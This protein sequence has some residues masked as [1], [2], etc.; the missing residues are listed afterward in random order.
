MSGIFGIVSTAG[1]A[2]GRDA[3]RPMRTTMSVWGKTG[4]EDT[5]LG[6]IALGYVADG[7]NPADNNQPLALPDAPEVTLVADVRL[8]DPEELRTELGPSARATESEAEL[9]LRAYLRWGEA[10][11]DRLYGAFAFAVADANRGVVLL[12]RD[13]I[14]QRPLHYWQGE[15]RLIF[16]TSAEAIVA[17]PLVPE[18]FDEL[19]LAARVTGHYGVLLER[20]VYAGV[21]K[22]PP[23][24][25]LVAQRGRTDQRRYWFPERTA[26]QDL[27][28]PVE[29]VHKLREALFRATR[30]AV[31][32]DGS[33]GAHVS[34]GLDSS[35]VAVLADR[36][37][38][39]HGRQLARVFSWSPPLE[40]P[41]RPEDERTRVEDVVRTIGAPVTYCD[42]DVRMLEADFDRELAM[43]P[44]DALL[45]EDEV[46]RQA[47][48][49][50]IEIILSGWGGDEVASFS[51]GG[52]SAEL[53]R[54]RQWRMLIREA[55]EPSRRTGTGRMRIAWRSA[56]T[57][58]HTGIGTMLPE[59]LAHTLR[60]QRRWSADQA[61]IRRG[62]HIHPE[63]PRLMREACVRSRPRPDM[64]ATRLIYL[65]SGHLTLR[66]E[67][68]AAAA[69]R[70]G[71]E[72]RYPL[73]DRGLI[74]L[75]LSFPAWLWRRDCESRWIFR[76]A[77]EPFVPSSVFQDPKEEPARLRSYLDL[78]LSRPSPPPDPT[79]PVPTVFAH[80]ARRRAQEAAREARRQ[81]P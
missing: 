80:T 52:R 60:L 76:A 8:D 73:L 57:I 41:V 75:C 37:L 39:A 54:T 55:A 46:L 70:V 25:V 71:A 66:L 59:P 24:H 47:Q 13:H 50:G 36:E 79:L 12:A 26:R 61:L 74:E 16:A 9:V 22:V 56:R 11:V 45:H 49:A 51:G 19:A 38:R 34:G 43:A 58:L 69:A 40:G 67:A 4:P 31:R 27:D 44:N 21:L 62:H 23:A 15:E 28:S 29:Y 65:G 48:R 30:A 68:W 2:V 7:R 81:L 72:Y 42:A 33:I 77:V 3:L 17:H 78:V 20:S 1:A 32:G 14:G 5:S 18:R 53:L 35:A 10:C 63:I 64:H 6:A